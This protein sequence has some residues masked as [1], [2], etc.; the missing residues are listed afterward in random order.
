MK[1]SLERWKRVPLVHWNVKKHFSYRMTNAGPRIL[2]VVL[3]RWESLSISLAVLL[4]QLLQPSWAYISVCVIRQRYLKKKSLIMT[5][6][7]GGAWKFEFQQAPQVIL[8]G[9]KV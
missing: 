6:L 7:S 1:T 8:M 5:Q 4:K 3:G 2:L 9:F